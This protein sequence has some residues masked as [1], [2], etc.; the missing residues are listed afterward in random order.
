MVNQRRRNGLKIWIV[1]VS[2]LLCLV[3]SL[4]P[5]AAEISLGEEK[6]KTLRMA[7]IPAEDIEEM[8]KAFEPGK[9]YL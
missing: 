7:L 4:L 2:G 5:M 8:I 9:Q 1:G 6:P 3:I